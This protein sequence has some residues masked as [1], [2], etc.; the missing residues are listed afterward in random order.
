[1]AYIPDLT[2]AAYARHRGVSRRMVN[3]WLHEGKIS[4]TAEKK[5]NRDEADQLLFNSHGFSMRRTTAPQNDQITYR[6]AR[7][8]KEYYL[9]RTAK[10]DYEIQ[11]GILILKD[12]VNKEAFNIARTVR[13]QLLAI[14]NRVSGLIAAESSREKV[15]KILTD[16]FLQAT[17][18][19]AHYCEE[20]KGES[21][22]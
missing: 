1:V 15:L 2:Q 3:K 22:S 16:E 9:G 14:P 17:E 21:A 8:Q 13:D 4:L 10:L 11:R 19:L 18:P 7:T 5:I 6:L 20:E 12:K